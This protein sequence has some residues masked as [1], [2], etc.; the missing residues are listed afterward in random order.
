MA[1]AVYIKKKPKILK[2]KD[3]KRKRQE[4]LFFGFISATGAAAIIFAVWPYFVWQI[5]TVPKISY[6][7]SAFPIP[8]GSV[9]SVK[10]TLKDIQVVQDPDGFSYFTTNYKPK[11]KR[12]KNFLLS[13]P[14]LE[15]VDAN[16]KVDS[17]N[18]EK[19]LSHFPGSAIPG[20]IGNSFITG[21]S[22]LPQFADPK[23]YKSIFSKLSDLDVGDD[24]IAE[25]D[26]KKLN[27]VVQYKKVVDPKDT[28]VIGQI[29]QSGK[30]LTLMTCVPPG[31]NLK[32]LIVIT[33]LI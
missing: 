27:F 24:I 20:E 28:S 17:L 30:N 25:V 7:V 14:K 31:T 16:V 29:S 6:S 21:H 19:N 15:I 26:G 10:D 32:R 9:L 13:I 2:Q 1:L 22:V 4:R 11:G 8:K 23:N 18:F 5:S 12:P 33:S 3:Q